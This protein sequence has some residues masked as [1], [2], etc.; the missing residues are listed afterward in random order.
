[1]RS[2]VCIAVCLSLAGSAHAGDPEP[3]AIETIEDKATVVFIHSGWG[4]PDER[5]KWMFQESRFIDGLLKDSYCVGYLEP[6]EK[7]LWAFAPARWHSKR[8]IADRFAKMSFDPGTIHYVAVPSWRRLTREEGERLL[9]ELEYRPGTREGIKKKLRDPESKRYGKWA[10]EYFEDNVRRYQAIDEFREAIDLLSRV[11][12]TID[13]QSIG[14]AHSLAS[15]AEEASYQG[16]RIA[17][18]WVIDHTNDSVLEIVLGGL[19]RDLREASSLE[20]AM[21]MPFLGRSLKL[22]GYCWCC[23]ERARVE[24]ER[25]KEV[26]PELFDT[27]NRGRPT[28]VSREAMATA[29]WTV[30]VAA[31]SVKE[32]L[33]E[34][35]EDNPSAARRCRI[36]ME[37][38]ATQAA[39]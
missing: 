29:L 31:T 27:S 33:A 2:V 14:A 16:R 13:S 17:T 10:F 36:S 23:V 8:D 12:E 15:R 5:L 39:E 19:P 34:V 32:C 26:A 1:M 6:G 9:S 24:L 3:P 22:E 25:T 37:P 30:S 4:H 20:L 11:A 38:S 18:E 28:F 35:R 21:V 7:W